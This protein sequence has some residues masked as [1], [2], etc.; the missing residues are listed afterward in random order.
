MYNINNIINII[1][2]VNIIISH[3]SKIPHLYCGI[4][5]STESSPF[6]YIKYR[7]MS[8]QFS[9]FLPYLQDRRW[10]YV[11]KSTHCCSATRWWALVP[12][13]SPK[14][15]CLRTSGCWDPR[16]CCA[17]RSFLERSEESWNNFAELPKFLL[18]SVGEQHY[19]SALYIYKILT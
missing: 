14:S 16:S 11:M 10:N 2:Q 19:F 4:C 9:Y 3:F 12:G 5:H 13:A 6:Q 1:I 18:I 8:V 15:W 17:W 7:N